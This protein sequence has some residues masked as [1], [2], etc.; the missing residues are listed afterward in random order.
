MPAVALVPQPDIESVQVDIA[1]ERTQDRALRGPF[2]VLD[3]AGV[4][5]ISLFDEM[6]DMIEL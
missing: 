2:G 1:D 5:K 3:L 4:L 6:I